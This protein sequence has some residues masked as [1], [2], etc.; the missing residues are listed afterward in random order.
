MDDLVTKITKIISRSDGSEVK[1][2]AE[3]LFGAGLQESVGV[4]VFRRESPEHSWVYCSDQ[5]HPDWQAMSVEE[6]VKHGRSEM[7]QTV[8]PGEMLAVVN[9]L[10][11][12]LSEFESAAVPEDAEGCASAPRT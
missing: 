2:V 4:D 6:Y 12:R 11:G 8:S 10:G 3:T 9:G 5:P 1:I 7:L